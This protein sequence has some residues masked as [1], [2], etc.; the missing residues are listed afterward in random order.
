[1]VPEI[2]PLRWDLKYGLVYFGPTR[3]GKIG[4]M[5]WNKVRLL[6]KHLTAGKPYWSFPSTPV[7]REIAGFVL[8]HYVD[9]EVCW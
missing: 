4:A 2:Q 5:S 1:M 7:T 8:A 9:T 3:S 6:H